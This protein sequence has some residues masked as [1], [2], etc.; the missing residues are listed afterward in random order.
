MVT[1]IVQWAKAPGIY[2]YVAGLIP[3]NTPRYFTKNI[4]SAFS[5]PKKSKKNKK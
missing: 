5:A 2:C 4:E 1:A 3:T